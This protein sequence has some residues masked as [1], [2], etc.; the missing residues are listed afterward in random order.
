MA[1]RTGKFN[2][3]GKFKVPMLRGLGSRAPFFHNG[4]AKTL[5]DVV[6]FYNT[7]FQMGLTADEIRKIVLFLQQA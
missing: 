5:T 4:G 7:R 3:L 6:N 1:L 2:D